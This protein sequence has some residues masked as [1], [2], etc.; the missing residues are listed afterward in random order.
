[1]TQP[2]ADYSLAFHRLQEARQELAQARS[3]LPAMLP[4][5]RA[6][7]LARCEANLAQMEQWLAR[8]SGNGP[9]VA[10]TADVDSRRDA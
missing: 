6:R 9:A 3:G 2:A 8:A 5:D 7:L 10:P 4:R 1:M